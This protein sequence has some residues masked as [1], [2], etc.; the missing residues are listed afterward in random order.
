[1]SCIFSENEF[2]DAEI[3]YLIYEHDKNAISKVTAA[4]KRRMEIK[5]EA[6]KSAAVDLAEINA[7]IQ[8]VESTKA[9]ATMP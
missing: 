8:K 2:S 7:R 1:M 4:Y 9:D 6:V 5:E 3:E